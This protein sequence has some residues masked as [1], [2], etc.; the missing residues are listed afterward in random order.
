ML[1]GDVPVDRRCLRV[2]GGTQSRR[3]R[4]FSPYD[5]AYC[6]SQSRW[7]HNTPLSSQGLTFLYERRFAGL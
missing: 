4:D 1:G 7:F 2:S 3:Q 6:R 5:A